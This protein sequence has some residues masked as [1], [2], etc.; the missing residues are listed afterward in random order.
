MGFLNSENASYRLQ[1][2]FWDR[3]SDACLT[4]DEIIELLPYN[5]IV[6]DQEFRYYTCV[7]CEDEF[8]GD[9]GA[10]VLVNHLQKNHS[11]EINKNYDD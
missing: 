2:G 10:G 8:D 9:K 1:S 5:F 6:D 4:Y 11:G 3:F 7:H